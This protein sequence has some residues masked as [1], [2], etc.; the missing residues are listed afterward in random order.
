MRTEHGKHAS[1]CPRHPLFGPLPPVGPMAD[2]YEQNLTLK[3]IDQPVHA[4][5]A[6]SG[7]LHGKIKA[8]FYRYRSVGGYDYVADFLIAPLGDSPHTRHGDSGAIWSLEVTP[9]ADAKKIPFEKCDLRPLAI[10]WGGQVFGDGSGRSGFA[11]AT[12]LSNVCKLLDFELVSDT[13]ASTATGDASAT[14]ASP[15][16]PSTSS[17]HRN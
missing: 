4:F 6:A 8:M 12:S 15:R 14:T 11:V 9:D 10:E 3:L 16:L 17:G 2:L 1:E 13:A 5:G 7:L